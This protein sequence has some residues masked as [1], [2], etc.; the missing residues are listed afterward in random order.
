MARRNLWRCHSRGTLEVVTAADTAPRVTVQASEVLTGAACRSDYD[1]ARGWHRVNLDGI[2]PVGPPGDEGNANDVIERVRL[3][4]TNPD[5]TERVARLLFEKSARGI[6]V[7]LGSPIT[8]VS[9]VLRDMDGNPTGIP[10]QLSKNWHTRPEGGVY[11]GVW[12]HGFSQVRLPPGA[13]VE[14]ELT[15][16]YAHWGGVAAASH[17][18]ALSD[19]LGQQPALEPECPGGLGREHLLRARSGPGAVLDHGRTAA[20]GTIHEP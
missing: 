8:G 11:A 2:V 7:R 1:A 10:V 5:S 3:M 20:D 4:L 13:K 6:R 19:R 16:V 17:C 9:A 15:I 12:F 14:L 18:A